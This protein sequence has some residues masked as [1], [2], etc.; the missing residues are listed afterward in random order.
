MTDAAAHLLGLN[1]RR[2]SEQLTRLVYVGGTIAIGEQAIVADAVEPL[3][4][5]VHQEAADELVR[6]ERHRFPAAGPSMR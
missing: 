2:G 5:H 3:G 4:Q 1:A 6:G